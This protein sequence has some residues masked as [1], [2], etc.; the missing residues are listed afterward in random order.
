MRFIHAADLHIDSPLRGL[1]RYEGA[2]VERLRGATRAAMVGLVDLAVEEAGA[3]V[4]LAGD[5]YDRDWPDFRTGL[6]FREQMVR[7]ERAGIPVLMVQGNHDAQGRIT[8]S[9]K[10]PDNVT[11]FSSRTAQTVRLESCGVAVHGRSFPEREVSEDWVPDYPDPIP[12]V[13]NIGL[14]HTSLTGRPGHDPYA[15]TDLAALRAK[16][17]DY[18]ALGHVHQREVV[19]EQTPRV[20]F[21]GNLQGRHANETGPKGCELVTVEGGR[22]ESRPVA[23]DT[24]RWSRLTLDL[25]ACGGGELEDVDGCR[26]PRINGEQARVGVGTAW[27]AVCSGRCAWR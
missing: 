14:L 18:W 2:P 11:L 3:F 20:L 24:V 21:S 9:L 27:A 7:L 4:L 19:H 13:F 1:D 17:Y 25:L 22:V 16:G 10:L 15:P 5:V 23:L 12:G 8:R 6:F 26:K